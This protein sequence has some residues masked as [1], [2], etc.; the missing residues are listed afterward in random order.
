MNFLSPFQWIAVAALGVL[1]YLIASRRKHLLMTGHQALEEERLEGEAALDAGRLDEAERFFYAAYDRANKL[2]DDKEGPL[3]VSLLNLAKLHARRRSWEDAERFAAEAALMLEAHTNP[4]THLFPEALDVMNEICLERGEMEKAEGNLH[5]SLE[6]VRQ[7]HGERSV[8]TADRLADIGDFLSDHSREADAI[9]YYQQAIGIHDKLGDSGPAAA[10]PQ[11]LLRLGMT[12]IRAGRHHDAIPALK[13]GLT[14][15][16]R[17]HGA[18]SFESAPFLDALSIADNFSGNN[19]SAADLLNRAV[20]LREEKLGAEHADVG[21]TLA[22]LADS[23]RKL[24]RYD[25][26]QNAASRALRIQEKAD[27]N[28]RHSTLETLALIKFE[29]GDHVLADEYFRN[30]L[31]S[32]RQAVGEEN[33][34]VAE[35]LE[36]HATIKRRLGETEA[37]KAMND[38]AEMI[39]K[40]WAEVNS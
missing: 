18:E 28:Q 21:A 36:K 23:L 2:R 6:F 25:E 24:R 15:I 14:W 39:R 26:A 33:L 31:L 30:A 13:R 35:Y 27:D 40:R 34:E 1:G 29:C 37:A 32:L 20:K 9:S 7:R 16:E 38:Q 4:N 5:R 12:M 10:T 19:N 22:L 17:F 11:L 8:E 3:A